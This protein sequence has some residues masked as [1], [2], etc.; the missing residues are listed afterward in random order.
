MTAQNLIQKHKMFL[1]KGPN[2]E[3][4]IGM[5]GKPSPEE[6]QNIRAHKSEITAELKRQQAKSYET[7][8]T[9]L[10]YKNNPDG[11]KTAQVTAKSSSDYAK[12]S[13]KHKELADQLP[14]MKITTDGND[15]LADKLIDNAKGVKYWPKDDPEMS[16]V[17]LG[18]DAKKSD[19][20]AAAQKHCSHPD[21]KNELQ[22][23]Y[24]ADA[25]HQ[26]THLCTCPKCMLWRQNK[27]EADVKNW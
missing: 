9:K 18:Q 27:K 14:D 24:T 6:I 3:D 2:G 17:N 19:Y 11:T 15:K 25:R 4:R 23:G 20:Y 21:L 7:P 1:Q 13:P 8:Q 12:L 22:A 10:Q 26:V 16:G 5:V